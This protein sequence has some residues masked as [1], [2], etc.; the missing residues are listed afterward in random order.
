MRTVEHRGTIT[1]VRPLVHGGDERLGTELP[2]RTMK[3]LVEGRPV[4]I[5]VL[6]G[7]AIR[8]V[9]RRVAAKRWLE[10]LYPDE[11]D[12]VNLV[13][14]DVYYV[15]FSG[16]SLAKG[17]ATSVV[18]LPLKAEIRQHVPMLSVFG[19]ALVNMMLEGKLIVDMAIPIARETELYTGVP[20]EVSI[21]ELVGDTFYTRK[22]DRRE[23]N[24]E[25]GQEAQQMK[26]E[27]E[28][29]AAGTQLAH[30]FVLRYV[31]PVELACFY[32]AVRT[33]EKEYGSFGGML[34]IGHGAVKWEYEPEWGDPTPYVQFVE[35]NREELR[36]WWFNVFV[37]KVL[38]SN[39]RL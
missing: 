27:V 17:A 3:F 14:D 35:D 24:R 13:P 16:G 10:L 5:P 21:Y 23:A 22:D 7:N 26:Y 6:S 1:L 39:W 37:S 11:K 4:D 2:V 38:K 25:E 28:Y 19:S 32:D 33:F 9:L 34:R 15:L 20:A 30:R 29:L 36:D 12:I 18:D 31:D 8:G